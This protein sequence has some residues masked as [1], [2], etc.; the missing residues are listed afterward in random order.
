M[1]TYLSNALFWFVVVGAALLTLAFVNH[2]K[3]VK[4]KLLNPLP[5]RSLITCFVQGEVVFSGEVLG[6]VETDNTRKISFFSLDLNTKLEI[7]NGA[8]VVLKKKP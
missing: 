4:P 2:H 6:V 1:K 5:P 7:F 8:C 3:P